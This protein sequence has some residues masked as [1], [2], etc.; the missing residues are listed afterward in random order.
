MAE[1]SEI[2]AQAKSSGS[3]GISMA[4]IKRKS[5]LAVSAGVKA[6]L[7]EGGVS[8]ILAACAENNAKA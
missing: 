2:T 1:I 8:R 5:A 6:N 7:S 3:G 4:K